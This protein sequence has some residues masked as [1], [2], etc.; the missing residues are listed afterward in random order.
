MVADDGGHRF[1]PRIVPAGSSMGGKGGARQ[2]VEA[3]DSL[4][5]KQL[6]NLVDLISE[7][8]IQGFANGVQ[9]IF[10]DGVPI[11]NTD[12]SMNF[13]NVNVQ[14]FGGWPN[15]PIMSGFDAQAS[16]QQVGTQ[17]K[18]GFPQVRSVVNGDVDRIRCT[19]A[20]PSLQI[21]DKKT[22]DINGTT[23]QFR[24]EVQYGH[25]GVW[26]NMGDYTISGKTSSRYQR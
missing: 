19:L 2:S 3:P 16:E 7:G 15:Q 17:L 9:D 11:Q 12:G 20:V 1:E 23:V 21:I 6:A 25:N 10:I 13:Q 4:K 14:I 24:A 8:P 18:Y 26:I 5:S 22:G